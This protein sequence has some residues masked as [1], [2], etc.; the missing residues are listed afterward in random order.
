MDIGIDF[1]STYSTI[2]IYRESSRNAEA[3]A[4]AQGDPA[5]IPSVVSLS[6]KGDVN[7]GKT[8]KNQ[9][10]YATY[11]IFEAF[12]MLLN[13]TNQEILKKRGY[14]DV[15]TPHWATKCFLNS[16]IRGAMKREEQKELG[17][18]V[19]CVPEIWGKGAQ[20]L[21]GRTI[22][23]NIIQNELDPAIKPKR[24][25]VTTEP[26]AASA[27]FA[28]Q[29]Q[30]VTR[31]RFNGYLLLID[32]GGGTLDIT[33]TEVRSSDEGMEIGRRESGG[34]GE[35]H[36]DRN[37]NISIGS[38]GI[39]FI[40]RIVELALRDAGL[41]GK[42]EPLDYTS[43]DVLRAI[44]GTENLLKSPD[45]I[46]EIEDTFGGFG[47]G[48]EDAE[49]ILDEESRSFG[50]I[51]Y[52]EEAVTI[53]YQQIYTAYKEVVAPVLAR[54][55]GIINARVEKHIHADPCDPAAGDRDDFKIALV[56]GFGTFYLVKK[57]ICDIYRLDTNS[58]LDKRT[59]NM[60]ADKKEQAISLGAA[61]L[62]AG[63]VVLQKVA[64]YSI[65]LCSTAQNGKRQ[66]D[67]GIRF[68]QI[69]ETGK[70]YFICYKDDPTR[71][72][73][74]AALHN[75]ITEFAIAFNEDLNHGGLM[76]LKGNMLSRLAQLPALGFWN[77]GFSMDD[78]EIISFHIVPD[79]QFPS[80]M[81]AKETVIPLDSYSN[82]FDLTQIRSI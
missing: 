79:P 74:Y 45:K 24:V 59:R 13:E 64:Q 76:R 32:Y 54:Q 30:Q 42:D 27:Y 80:E 57:Q 48:Y 26:E 36:P 40:Q 22:L 65:G 16:I 1:G 78:N 34:A 63:K 62:A 75:N 37:G 25:Q 7:Y 41:L 52:Q 20:T 43:R 10:G 21:D 73:T 70:T 35:N 5:S 49:G 44:N 50:D 81:G 68:H 69:L 60:A 61:L 56:G 11:R 39:A 18:V 33:L 14:D 67:Y 71:R 4:L 51:E 29:Y 77:C 2:S 46:Q 53:T 9:I 12:K 6:K 47:S 8:A 38:A 17:N 66:L 15:H 31:Q 28:Y 23:R 58:K 19:I 55:V 3:I 72:V 82:M